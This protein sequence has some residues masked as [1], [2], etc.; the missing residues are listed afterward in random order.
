MPY[1]SKGDLIEVQWWE[2]NKRGWRR[3]VAVSADYIRRV[4][5]TG[6]FIEDW[7]FVPSVVCLVPDL[8]A[9]GTARLTEVRKT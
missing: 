5:G 9:K 8:N 3:A 4:P 2:G 1:I 6:E 7:T